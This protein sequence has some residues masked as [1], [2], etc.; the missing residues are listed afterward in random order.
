MVKEVR[1]VLLS[2][3]ENEITVCPYCGDEKHGNSYGCCGESSCHFE[4]AYVLK[5]GDCVTEHECCVVDDRPLGE[6][7]SDYVWSQKLRIKSICK[8]SPGR[9]DTTKFETYM[10]RLNRIVTGFNRV[11]F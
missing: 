6:R 10:Y 8:S 7:V 4:K 9:S 3:I 1:Q 2:Q 11:K 5:D